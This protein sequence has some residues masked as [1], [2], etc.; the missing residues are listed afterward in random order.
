MPGLPIWV[1]GPEVSYEPEAFLNEFPMV[2]GIM[3]G[4]G[5]ETFRE[6][7]EYYVNP[8]HSVR[9]Q[10]E[11]QEDS[12][13]I[14][15]NQQELQNISGL[16]FRNSKNELVRTSRREPISMDMLP[17]CYDHMEDFE[18]RIIYYE[19]SR[20]CP[21]SCSYCLSSIEKGL[22]F[23]SLHLVKK[24]LQ[25]FL[26][27]EVP[28]VKFVDRTFNCNHNHAVEI[29]SYIKEHDNGITNFHF[30]ISADLLTEEEIALIAEMRLSLIHI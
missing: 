4:E 15:K 27:H 10:T 23:R 8:K 24:E 6:L 1:G 3:I 28:Q 25:F 5:E 21:F 11:K 30:E 7:C 22:R 16:L 19:T 26:D 14:P 12:A 17:F 29:W 18:N 9:N 13:T 2:K 20:G